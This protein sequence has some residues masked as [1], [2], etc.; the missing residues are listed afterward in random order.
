MLDNFNWDAAFSEVMAAITSTTT[1]VLAYRLQT[2]RDKEES[3]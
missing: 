3:E 2:K 1:V